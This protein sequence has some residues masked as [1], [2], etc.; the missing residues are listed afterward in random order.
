[1]AKVVARFRST[2]LL[3]ALLITTSIFM[4]SL[5]PRAGAAAPMMM[6]CSDCKKGET[7]DATQWFSNGMYRLET[8]LIPNPMITMIRRKPVVF[9]A[10]DNDQ[11]MEAALRG[12]G[13]AG[14]ESQ[15]VIALEAQWPVLTRRVRYSYS[16][17]V[18]PDVPRD[19]YDMYV[20][21][22]R[23][24]FLVMIG[25]DV[26]TGEITAEYEGREIR[27]GDANDPQYLETFD[28]LDDAGTR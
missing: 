27:V 28:E 4:A 6:H 8:D 15:D 19:L 20:Q 2:T 21:V 7:F 14:G 12:V 22:G 5:Y 11:L 3:S 1:M 18:A 23:K 10:K 13:N 24:K 16:V 25:L 26:N 17:F 9:T